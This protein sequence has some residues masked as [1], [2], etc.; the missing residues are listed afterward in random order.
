MSKYSDQVDRSILDNVKDNTNVY[1]TSTNN[2]AG[3][4]GGPN[5]RTDGGLKGIQNIRVKDNHEDIDDEWKQAV[6]NWVLHSLIQ[7]RNE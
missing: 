5:Y 2:K 6:V 1:Q 3:S 7:N 4:Y